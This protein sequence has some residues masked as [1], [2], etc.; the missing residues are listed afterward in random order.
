MVKY[1]VLFE[2]RAEF[3]STIY[4]SFHFRGLKVVHNCA[5]T[6]FKTEIPSIIFNNSVCTSKKTH[7][8]IIN[9]I[10]W[11]MLFRRSLTVIGVYTEN[12]T[13]LVNIK[14]SDR[15]C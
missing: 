5:R 1:G 9:E 13:E 7:Q 6:L 8:F 2:A 10:N 11:L 15:D 3:L 14:F 4:T 12:H